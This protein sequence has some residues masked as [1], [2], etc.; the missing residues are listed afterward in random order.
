MIK[1]MLVEDEPQ[2]LNRFR[3]YI[4]SYDGD[5]EIAIEATNYDQAIEKFKE[6][7]VDAIFTDIVIPGGSGLAFIEEIKK[8][9]YKGV[10][11]IVSGYDNFNYAQKAIKLGASD[12]LLKPIFKSDYF[13]MLDKIMNQVDGRE[14]IHNK[15]YSEKLPQHVRKAMKYVERNYEREIILTNVSKVACVSSTYLS[16][17][18]SKILNIT[19]V[20]FVKYYRVEV[21]CKLLENVDLTLEE[22]AEKVGFCDNSYLNRCFKKI[23][24]ISP[25]KFRTDLMEKQ[26]YE[27]N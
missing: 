7:E 25:G 9:G 10:V 18:F 17:S 26:S 24:G 12:Y 19:F 8:L 22:V 20:D 23:K 4:N 6:Q 16:S 15:Y 3:N 2:A 5:F 14:I 21:A 11:V 13:S 27:E 1:L